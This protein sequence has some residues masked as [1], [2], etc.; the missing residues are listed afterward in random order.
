MKI[1]TVFDFNRA[2]DAGAYAWPGG[3]PYFYVMDDGEALSV[4]AANENAG[5]IR[6]SI[7]GDLRDGW[8]AVELAINWDDTGLYCA[9]TGQ[10]IA[11]AY[12]DD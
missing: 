8:H 9:H 3:Y 1:K 6:D 11:P 12:G 10:R 5:L 7:I 4:E 2:L